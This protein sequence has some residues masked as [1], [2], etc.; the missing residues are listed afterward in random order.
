[1]AKFNIDDRVVHSFLGA[2]TITRV[3]SYGL[4]GYYIYFDETPP[5]EYNMGEN[6]TYE[7]RD[8]ML[9]LEK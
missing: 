4:K 2:G 5:I 8:D 9:E 7:F 3:Q 1:M 6:P